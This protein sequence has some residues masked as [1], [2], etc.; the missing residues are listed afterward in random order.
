MNLEE[1][2]NPFETRYIENMRISDYLFLMPFQF[3]IK[4]VIQFIICVH[5]ESPYQFYQ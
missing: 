3:I 2:N 5:E 1:S 4:M